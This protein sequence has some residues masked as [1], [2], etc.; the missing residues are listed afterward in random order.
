M[1]LCRCGTTEEQMRAPSQGGLLINGSADPNS[2]C[3]PYGV[4]I[5]G[6]FKY[7]ESEESLRKVANSMSEKV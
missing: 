1:S 2:C 5:S 3:A 7:V 6:I 4:E